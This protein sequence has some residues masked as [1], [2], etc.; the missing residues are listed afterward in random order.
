[1]SVLSFLRDHC[2][3]ENLTYVETVQSLW[4]GY[5]SIERWQCDGQSLIVKR[6][7]PP[8]QASHPHGWDTDL[9]HRRKLKSYQVEQHW[10]AHIRKQDAFACHMPALLASQV[11]NDEQ[12]MLLED[13]QAQGYNCHVTQLTHR[14][15]GLVVDWLAQFHGHFLHHSGK[16]L[17]DKGNYWHL[18]TRPEEWARMDDTELQQHAADIDAELKGAKYQTLLHGDAKLANFGFS[19]DAVAA[20]DFQYVGR[21]VGIEDLAY[22][23]GSCLDGQQLSI[24]TPSWLAR[25][26]H[27]LA[28]SLALRGIDPAPVEA[29][30]RGLYDV[31]LADFTRFLNG[32]APQHWK[33]NDT[34]YQAVKRTLARY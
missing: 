13:L 20:I 3:Y 19:N 14:Q 26:F 15:I 21:G 7:C 2:R 24:Q 4:S 17:W 1:M 28:E 22:F 16:G 33:L 10:Y 34:L 18:D 25:Y 12:Y 23:L 32:W 11:C 30:W 9:S 6:I 5:G 8:N 31:A 27:T 29:E